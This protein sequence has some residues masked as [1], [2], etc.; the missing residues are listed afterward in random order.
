MAL[1]AFEKAPFSAIFFSED[2]AEV[3]ADRR[4]NLDPAVN[5][6]SLRATWATDQIANL[7]EHAKS[8]SVSGSRRCGPCCP[9]C[10]RSDELCPTNS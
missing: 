5:R 9:K 6:M 3:E 1:L 7:A 10:L 8:E 4:A 2:R